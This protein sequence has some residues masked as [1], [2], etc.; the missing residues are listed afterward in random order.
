MED[1]VGGELHNLSEVTLITSSISLL[2][3]YVIG[4]E[5]PISLG[6]A[7]HPQVRRGKILDPSKRGYQAWI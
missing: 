5:P 7:T 6:P 1:G 3:R 4:S 2:F